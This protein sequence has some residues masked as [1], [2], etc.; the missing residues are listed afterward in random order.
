MGFKEPGTKTRKKTKFEHNNV[1]Y[2][3]LSDVCLLDYN[4]QPKIK[5]I[6]IQDFNDYKINEGK[7]ERNE[8][9]NIYTF[10]SWINNI[11]LN[12]KKI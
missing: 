5:T 11:L 12:T 8:L 10:K 3:F 7:P 2:V 6:V 1:Y 9:N 4:K